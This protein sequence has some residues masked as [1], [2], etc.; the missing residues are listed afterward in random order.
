MCINLFRFEN[1]DIIQIHMTRFCTICFG[2]RVNEAENQAWI[3]K[4]STHGY[5]WDDKNPQIIIINS[6]AVTKKA[7]REITQCIHKLS[8][9]H[10][11]AQIFVTGCTASLWLREQTKTSSRIVLVSRRELMQKVLADFPIHIN[12][13]TAWHDK[14]VQ[15]GRYVVKIQDGCKRFCTYCIVPYLRGLPTS[16]S[17]EKIIEILTSFPADKVREIIFTAINTEYFGQG[18]NETLEQ[19]IQTVLKSYDSTIYPIRLSFG[20]I[21][22]YSLD[23]SFLKYY[24]TIR[25]STSFVHFFHIPLQSGSDTVLKRMNRGYTVSE[26]DKKIQHIRSLNKNAFFATDVITGFLGESEKE[27]EETYAY[28]KNSP[29]AKF[30]VFRYSSREGTAAQTLSKQWKPVLSQVQKERSHR[31]I[32]LSKIKYR[33]FLQ[34]QIGRTSPCLFIGNNKKSLQKG[35]IDNQIPIYIPTNENLNAVFKQVKITKIGSNN[36]LYGQL[37]S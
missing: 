19:L 10:R 37:I 8:R 32:E 5:I 28:L 24:R 14:F 26:F 27:F 35:L 2:C 30:H 9:L 18:N 6:C 22:P 12:H 34:T 36:E 25:E 21:N 11:H 23:T 29:L 4:L 17:I 20:S 3:S 13:R 16:V 7:V 33:T 1:I 15:S 31:L